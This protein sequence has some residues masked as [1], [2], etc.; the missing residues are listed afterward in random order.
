MEQCAIS[1]LVPQNQSFFLYV[2]F[3]KRDLFVLLIPIFLCFIFLCCLLSVMTLPLKPSQ[4]KL[5]FQLCPKV[6]HI[7]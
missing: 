7:G 3:M 2:A 4:L 1:L 6:P 5:G